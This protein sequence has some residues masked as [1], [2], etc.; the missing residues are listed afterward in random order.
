MPL[1]SGVLLG[2]DEEH[3]QQRMKAKIHDMRRR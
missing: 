3:G 2:P 1:M